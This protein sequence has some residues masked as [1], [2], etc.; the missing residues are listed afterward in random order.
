MTRTMWQREVS[1][2]QNYPRIPPGATGRDTPAAAPDAA[3]RAIPTGAVPLKKVP[4]KD[5]P[6]YLVLTSLV[7]A[8]DLPEKEFPGW[9]EF[10][11]YLE[12]YAGERFADGRERERFIKRQKNNA[13]TVVD[14]II[15]EDAWQIEEEHFDTAR[16][17]GFGVLKSEAKLYYM[18]Q[19]ILGRDLPSQLAAFQALAYGRIEPAYLRLFASGEERARLQKNLGPALYARVL[20]ALGIGEP[21]R[22]G[23][24]G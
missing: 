20:K 21:V 22:E 16:L 19:T 15:G 24:G 3:A 1:I 7:L 6:L 17:C 11:A 12:K 5:L 13:V 23:S 9:E 14:E 10:T 4:V 2:L 18:F 8:G